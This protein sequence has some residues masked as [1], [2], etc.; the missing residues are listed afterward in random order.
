[1]GMG[2]CIEGHTV[3]RFCE[4]C[5]AATLA[6]LALA[7]CGSGEL[8]PLE[9]RRHAPPPPPPGEQCSGVDTDEAKS[10][11]PPALAA[12]ATTVTTTRF[13]DFEIDWAEYPLPYFDAKI[14]AIWGKGVIAANG[15]YYSAVGDGNSPADGLATDGNTILYEYD[16]ASRRLRAVGDVLTAFGM[17][18]AGETGYGKIQGQIGEGPCGLLYMHTYWGSPTGV[19]YEGNY[20]GD[21]LLRYNPWTEQLESLGVKIPR[22]GVPSMTL[23]RSAGLIYGE[24]NTHTEPKE[25]IFWAYEIASDAIVFQ[26]P[27][28][29]RNDRSIAVD[30][31]GSAYYMGVGSDLYRY[32]ARI[33]AESPLG[34]AFPG[35]GWLRASTRIAA[36]GA[37]VMVTTQPDEAYLFDPSSTS[38]TLLATLPR[39]IAD[40][41]M[42]PSE[43][44]AYYVPVGLDGLPGFEL[45]ELD[46][47]TGSVRRVVDV[48]AAIEA[49]GG[50]R[51]RGG[52][53]INASPDGRTI[54]VAANSGEPDGFGVPVFIAIHLP[55]SAMP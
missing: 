6:A 2:R 26:S 52:Y 19:V 23:F 10:F 25:V 31:D 14:W 48:G 39:S 16:P 22:L 47:T 33:N 49:A 36:D 38:L 41:E 1:M 3:T 30:L 45:N 24:A 11:I 55:A 44:V 9:E 7:A 29:Q 12:T 35:G 20:Q 18:V 50:S 37:I 32:D 8:D 40:I 42:D 28:R 4:R 51:P 13:G 27:R 43:R 5:C 53:S 46:R 34:V 21:L 15:R 54:Y 17:H